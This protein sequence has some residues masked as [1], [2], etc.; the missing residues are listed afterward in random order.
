MINIL[1][2]YLSLQS[3]SVPRIGISEVYEVDA[4]EKKYSLYLIV[5]WN[6]EKNIQVICLHQPVKFTKIICFMQEQY[7]QDAFVFPTWMS[8]MEELPWHARSIPDKMRLPRKVDFS[9]S[10]ICLSVT[11]E[12]RVMI[13]NEI[14]YELIWN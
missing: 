9:H 12:S 7:F 8:L 4:T 13:W 1:F 10:A 6:R 2:I 11:L 5:N 3:V 14:I